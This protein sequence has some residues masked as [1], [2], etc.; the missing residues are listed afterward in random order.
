MNEKLFF[1]FRGKIVFVFF[2][3]FFFSLILEVYILRSWSQAYVIS[4]GPDKL[5]KVLYEFRHFLH[6][7]LLDVTQQDSQGAH[8]GPRCGPTPGA[9]YTTSRWY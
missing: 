6:Q 3:C 1:I 8:P 7:H 5:I 9:R 2:L 4:F